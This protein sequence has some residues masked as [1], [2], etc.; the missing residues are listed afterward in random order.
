MVHW[1]YLVLIYI[2][3]SFVVFQ[4]ENIPDRKILGFY[5]IL[6]PLD[7]ILVIK[8]W[9]CYWNM[10]RGSRMYLLLRMNSCCRLS[11][12]W[13]QGNN[14]FC[15]CR[16]IL[17]TKLWLHDVSCEMKLRN[18]M[19]RFMWFFPNWRVIVG[20]RGKG[21]ER[22]GSIATMK[23]P[24][25]LCKVT[26]TQGRNSKVAAPAKW[27]TT[28]STLPAGAELNNAGKI[29]LLQ[30]Y[31][32]QNVFREDTPKYSERKATTAARRS[33]AALVQT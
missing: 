32:Q 31:K 28:Q 1:L 6:V 19:C 8:W 9:S 33:S 30:G 12:R 11:C 16:H 3:C 17:V 4:W 24:K 22:P 10:A 29:P 5:E 2:A 20:F 7:E 26:S 15:R 18:T 27:K 13:L 25:L 14:N 21:L 23:P